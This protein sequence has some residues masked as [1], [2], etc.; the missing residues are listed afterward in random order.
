M[1]TEGLF[2]PGRLYQ[3]LH[4]VEIR[5]NL[6]HPMKTKKI[7]RGQILLFNKYSD[8]ELPGGVPLFLYKTHL[9]TFQWEKDLS[10]I[11][12]LLKEYQ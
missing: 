10:R 4:D 8:K 11:Y 12:L 5:I 7:E 3:L 6:A 9:V 2:V 1:S